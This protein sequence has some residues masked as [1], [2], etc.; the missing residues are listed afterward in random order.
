MNMNHLESLSTVPGSKPKVPGK[1]EGLPLTVYSLFGLKKV[2][3][4]SIRLPT[5][6]IPAG[7]VEAASESR[8]SAVPAPARA[9]FFTLYPCAKYPFVAKTVPVKPRITIM[10]NEHM[11]MLLKTFT[12]LRFILFP[13]SF[14]VSF[15]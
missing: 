1:P 2:R 8:G 3:P 15:R 7:F 12:C 14:L 10:T 6:T 5:N 4:K 11:K 9:L 13:S